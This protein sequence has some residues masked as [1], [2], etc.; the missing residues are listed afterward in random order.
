MS[1]RKSPFDVEEWASGVNKPDPGQLR[2]HLRRRGGSLLDIAR[3]FR[4]TEGMALDAVNELRASG[5]PIALYGDT[6]AVPKVTPQVEFSPDRHL[7]KSDDE[8]RYRFGVISDT[9]LGSKHERLDVCETLYDWFEAE[10]VKTVLHGGNWIEGE[11]HFN[12]H[13]LLDC[14][15]GRQAQLEYMIARY[16]HRPGIRTLYVTGDDHEGWYNQ[17]DGG[18]IGGDLE[19]LARQRG[20]DDLVNCGY[21]ESFFT[22][23]HARTGESAKLL[24]QH[25]GGGSAY[26]LSYAPQKVIESLQP[27]EKPAVVIFGHWHKMEFANIRGVWSLQAGCTKDLDTFGRKKRLS[28][29]VGG[30]I[31]ELHQSERGEIDMAVPHMRYFYDRSYY[32]GQ[33]SLHGMSSKVRAPHGS[34]ELARQQPASPNDLELIFVDR[35]EIQ[36][37]LKVS[38]KTLLR[39]ERDGRFPARSSVPGRSKK[40]LRSEVQAYIDGLGAR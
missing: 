7:I 18:D 32:N 19:R 12:K 39:M 28:Y 25:P 5:V 3:H 29:H 38:D 37:L 14:A 27:G 26:A 1:T 35:E 34:A 20:R 2:D 33:F 21:V 6:Y 13:E 9:H 15:H 30:S 10:G 16:P 8:G 40:W 23:E 24:L 22:L 17:S 36:R 31:L 11:K 4:C